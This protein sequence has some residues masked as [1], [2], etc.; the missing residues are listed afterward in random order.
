[1][2]RTSLATKIKD[3][4]LAAACTAAVGVVMAGAGMLLVHDKK[5][6]R[7]EDKVNI[8]LIKVAPEAAAAFGLATKE[9]LPK[10]VPAPVPVHDF[11]LPIKDE[12]SLATKP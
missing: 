1:M 10:P 2:A 9:P 6:D 12:Q 5:I 3:N 8:V 11:A 7:I 4:L